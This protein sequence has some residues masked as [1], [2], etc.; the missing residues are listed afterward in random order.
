MESLK[1]IKDVAETLEALQDDLTSGTIRRCIDQLQSVLDNQIDLYDSMSPDVQN[2]C[3]GEKVKHIIEMVDYCIS[4]LN[5][6]LELDKDD[7]EF[8]IILSVVIYELKALL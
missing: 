6:M 1:Q 3:N 4:D 2:C 8:T 5:E 7:T